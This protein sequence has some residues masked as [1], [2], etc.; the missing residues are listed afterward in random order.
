MR[1]EGDISAS[2]D[3][4]PMF[5]ELAGFIPCDALSPA[6]SSDSG[7]PQELGEFTE[8]T[9]EKLFPDFPA[10]SSASV[11]EQPSQFPIPTPNFFQPPTV[12]LDLST[13][14]MPQFDPALF[15]GVN[16]QQP[17]PAFD[18]DLQYKPVYGNDLNKTPSA[19]LEEFL[20][21]YGSGYFEGRYEYPELQRIPCPSPRS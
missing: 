21:T 5:P 6:E 9:W 17:I 15:S 8:L 12:P 14:H 11:F 4:N 3:M 7:I 10:E 19:G 18:A 13:L 20:Q 16:S 1:P 2:L